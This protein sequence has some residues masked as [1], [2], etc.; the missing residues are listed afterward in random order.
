MDSVNI[1]D[2]D[3]VDAGD[4]ADGDFDENE[5]Q[6]EVNDEDDRA[7]REGMPLN[8]EVRDE[9]LDE[10]DELLG[11]PLND[12]MEITQETEEELLDPSHAG[13]SAASTSSKTGD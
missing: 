8:I 10:E 11:D 13:P 12:S 4:F 9:V 1:G 5:D 2:E 7:G 6:S 3:G